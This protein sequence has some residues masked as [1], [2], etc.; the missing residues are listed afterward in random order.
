[1]FWLRHCFRKTSHQD[2][3]QRDSPHDAQRH[4]A[5]GREGELVRPDAPAATHVTKSRHVVL[6]D[7]SRAQVCWNV[8]IPGAAAACLEKPGV[9]TD[10][11]GCK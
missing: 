6:A 4:A 1:M 2:N 8:V 7:A 10:L 11:E 9:S 5:E 3:H